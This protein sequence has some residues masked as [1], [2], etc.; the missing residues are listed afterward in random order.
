MFTIPLVI[1]LFGLILSLIHCFSSQLPIW[2]GQFGLFLVYCA[3]FFPVW[4]GWMLIV[5]AYLLTGIF[6][7]R[8]VMKISI[9]SVFRTI[10]PKWHTW[11]LWA[12]T[13]PYALIK[14]RLI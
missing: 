3:K 1:F 5:V 12:I 11:I 7:F 8:I 10:E 2:L 4:Q 13:W 14:L 6:L 9:Y